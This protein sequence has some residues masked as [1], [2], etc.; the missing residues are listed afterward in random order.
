MTGTLLSSALPT[1]AW[2]ADAACVDSPDPDVFF[3]DSTDPEGLKAARS[4]C[5]ACPVAPECLQFAIEARPSHGIWAGKTARQINNM[6]KAASGNER[7]A[8]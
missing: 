3:A 2:H 7:T 8:A 6:T 5:K 4:L 1:M